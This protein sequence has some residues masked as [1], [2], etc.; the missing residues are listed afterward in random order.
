MLQCQQ[1]AVRTDGVGRTWNVLLGSP[2]FCTHCI[3]AGRA[4]PVWGSWC[5][6]WALFGSPGSGYLGEGVSSTGMC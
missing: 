3:A 2:C 1:G 5:C 4:M 6:P